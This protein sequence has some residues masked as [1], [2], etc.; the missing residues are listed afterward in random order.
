MRQ[1]SHWARVSAFFFFLLIKYR[2]SERTSE[3]QGVRALPLNWKDVWHSCLL[4]LN[5]DLGGWMWVCGA[6]RCV[7][8]D[9]HSA[10]IKPFL[11]KDRA[12]KQMQQLSLWKWTLKVRY[13]E[14][15]LIISTETFIMLTKTF[16]RPF[17]EL[18]GKRQHTYAYHL[19]SLNS[20]QRGW[21]KYMYH[22]TF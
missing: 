1:L 6:G 16:Y 4:T 10:R 20:R 19:G 12:V 3:H 7:H 13:T 21:S 14:N 11:L 22:M 18:L 2:N 9:C 17:T 5:G 8:E 15:P